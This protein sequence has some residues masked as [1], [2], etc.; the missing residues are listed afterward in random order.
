MRSLIEVAA[1]T[2]ELRGNTSKPG[3]ETWP[4]RENI[5]TN[6]SSIPSLSHCRQINRPRWLGLPGTA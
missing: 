1:M 2:V 4:S 5:G 6:P 3:F